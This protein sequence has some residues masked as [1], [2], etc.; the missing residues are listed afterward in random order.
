MKVDSSTVKILAVLG[1]ALVGVYVLKNIKSI[2]SGVGSAVPA[3]VGG[4]VESVGEII[5]VPPTN[6]DMC[7]LA[8]KEGRRFDASLYCGA[9][10]F[11][12][13]TWNG[14]FSK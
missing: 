10:R 4:A 9:G 7:E 3:A 5:G 14:E 2:A 12:S 13:A 11:I 8:I 1:V 6:V